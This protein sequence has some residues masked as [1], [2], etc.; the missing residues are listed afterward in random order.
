MFEGPLQN[1]AAPV[2]SVVNYL[3]GDDLL[4][5][6]AKGVHASDLSQEANSFIDDQS[7]ERF[8]SHGHKKGRGL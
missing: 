3:V 4:R 1:A 8:S 5:P 6:G 2:R 7:W